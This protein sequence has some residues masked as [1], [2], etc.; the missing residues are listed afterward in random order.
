MMNPFSLAEQTILVTGASSGIGRSIAIECSKMGA[1]LIIT[2]RNFDRLNETYLQLQGTGHNFY[3][4][5]LADHGALDGFIS[6]FKVPINGLVHSAGILKRIPL[7]F[8]NN[9]NFEEMMSVNFFSPAHLT[10]KLYKK[11]LLA[12]GSSIVFISSVAASFASLGNIMYMSSKGALNSFMKGIAFEL[13]SASIR[14]NAIQPGMVKTNLTIS[15]PDEEI[16]KDIERYPLKRYGKPE[17]VAYAVI[18]LLSNASQWMT[19][20]ILTLD[21]GLTLR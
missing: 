1:K 6:N 11:K 9:T 10:Q 2:G 17:E 21:G 8:I 3:V 5:D 15:I 19:G 7:K 12:T 13:A 18:Y 14:V 16:Q 20:S 4:C